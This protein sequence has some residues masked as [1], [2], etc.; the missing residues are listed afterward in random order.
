MEEL[1]YL[2]KVGGTVNTQQKMATMLHR[3]KSPSH[4]RLS[5]I[6]PLSNFG[7]PDGAEGAIIGVSDGGVAI[8]VEGNGDAPTLYVPWQNVSY[9]ADGSQLVKGAAKG[10]KK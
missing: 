2:L 10:G 1:V 8:G 6:A 5:T 3:Q 7:F 4:V 9:L